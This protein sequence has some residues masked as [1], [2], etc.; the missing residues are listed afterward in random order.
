VQAHFLEEFD[1]ALFNFPFFA[2]VN[3]SQLK[4]LSMMDLLYFV[5]LNSH[6]TCLNL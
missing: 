3:H 1:S 4:C 5:A 6:L 2:N